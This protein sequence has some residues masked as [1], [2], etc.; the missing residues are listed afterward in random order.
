[1]PAMQQNKSSS[2]LSTKQMFPLV[3]FATL[4]NYAFLPLIVFV[5]YFVMLVSIVGPGF[6]SRPDSLL[7]LDFGQLTPLTSDYKQVKFEKLEIAD[8]LTEQMTGLMNRRYLCPDCGMLFIFEEE[9]EQNFWMKNT[10]VPLDIIFIDNEGEIVNIAKNTKVNQ[11]EET[12]PSIARARYVLEVN[13]GWSDKQKLKQG[14]R[15]D[16]AQI[17][18]S[19]TQYQNT[20]NIFNPNLNP[21]Q[22]DSTQNS[23][24]TTTDGAATSTI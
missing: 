18:A 15:L 19:G 4:F 9:D 16:M 24:P 2:S 3:L 14:D 17:I 13:A 8:D 11:T 12:Y 1:M 21:P 22:N 23:N 10:F 6:S 7:A 5:L 20:T